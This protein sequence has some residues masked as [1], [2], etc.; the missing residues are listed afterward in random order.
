MATMM[1]MMMMMMM[2]APEQLV[3]ISYC[4]MEAL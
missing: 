2:V 4:M 1:M 3:N